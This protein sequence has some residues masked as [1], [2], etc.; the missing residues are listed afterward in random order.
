MLPRM[1]YYGDLVTRNDPKRCAL[2]VLT[3]FSTRKRYMNY[4]LVSHCR[5]RLF[6]EP[7][8]YDLHVTISEAPVTSPWPAVLTLVVT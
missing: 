4:N 2:R 6:I 7:V 3:A 5:T 8:T 1:M